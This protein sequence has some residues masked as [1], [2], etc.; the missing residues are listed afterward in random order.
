MRLEVINGTVADRHLCLTC[1][2]AINRRTAH[3][4]EVTHCTRFARDHTVMIVK[5][6]GH[7]PDPPEAPIWMLGKA[8]FI[9]PMID[10]QIEFLTQAQVED[11]DFMAAIRQ[12]HKPQARARRRKRSTGK[13]LKQV[14]VDL[15]F[16]GFAPEMSRAEE[17]ER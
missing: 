17:P 6:D 8:L 5:C 1:R 9:T 12:K 4:K 11:Y 10:G 7:T 16:K 3:G 2:Y 14:Q 15:P 13:K